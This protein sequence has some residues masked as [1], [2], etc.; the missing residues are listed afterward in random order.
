M[1]E[2]IIKTLHSGDQEQ[3]DIIFS[4]QKNILVEAPAGH[5]KTKTMVS[6]IAYLIATNKIPKPKKI[7][8]LTFSVNAAYKIKQEVAEKLPEML[9][10]G[11]L[12]P[13][14]IKHRVLATNY[15][16]FCRRILSLY[17]YLLD[18]NLKK[19]NSL[20]G[21]G[22]DTPEAIAK[23]NIGIPGEVAKK[24][25]LYNDAVKKINLKY[26]KDNKEGYLTAVSAYLLPKNFISFNAI[27]LFA[28]E[29]LIKHKSIQEF[30]IRY[31]STVI[32]DE[33]QDT[34]ILS[35]TLLTKLIGANSQVMFIGDS[36][37]RIYGFIGAIPNLM[38]TAQKKYNAHR[39]E[40]KKNYRFQ[41]NQILLQL[42]KNIRENAKNPRQPQ[43]TL[44]AKTVLHLWNSQPEE[45][46]GVC[47]IVR[48]HIDSHPQ[49]KVAVLVKKRG[50]DTTEILKSLDK[51]HLSYFYA[52]YL[53]D[54]AEYIEFHYACLKEL[55][56]ILAVSKNKFNK[57]IGGKFVAKIREIYQ[58]K[59]TEVSKSLIKLLD[60]FIE[61][62]F[63]DY[64]FL[65]AEEKIEFIRDT[66][67]SRALK[68]YLSYVDSNVVLST[69]HGAKGL[70][71]DFVLLPDME[72]YSFPNFQALCGKDCLFQRNCKIL[73]PSV[74]TQSPYENFFLNELS[75]FY[76]AATR[77]K[78]NLEF[79]YSRTGLDYKGRQRPINLS[80]LLK[81]DGIEFST[82][83][84][85]H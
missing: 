38:N 69:V 31:F 71:W 50:A 51:N 54:D 5:G 23:L 40:L 35:W 36:L 37:Q 82:N 60:T 58:E 12:S 42:D 30:Y 73:W 46:D 24:M 11:K 6:R 53:D 33:F 26:L 17:G 4:A 25:A 81:L 18:P 72:Q 76:V 45:A 77:A 14:D 1:I 15:H 79:S 8:A 59:E 9:I 10:A 29:L 61:K 66:F 75:V 44:P 78:K 48:A 16:G 32:V 64:K 22:G 27:L 2:E 70:E 39:V 3:L 47:A 84:H 34:N 68:Q 56:N 21:I 28:I 55:S 67:E 62:L 74:A 83:D 41:N 57:L 63:N 19:I 13:N 52:L 49:S 7:L 20:M 80:C 65:S 85:T 43:I